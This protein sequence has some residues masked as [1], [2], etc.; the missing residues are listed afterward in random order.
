[1]TEPRGLRATSAALIC[2]ALV[3][4]FLTKPVHLD[5][6]NFLVLAKGAAM[7][8]WRPHAISINWQGTTER[9]F[10]VLSN[11][12]GIG[13]WLAPLWDAPVWAQRMWI[14]L[15]YTSDP[16]EDLTRLVCRC[17]AYT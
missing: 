15:L 1:M 13:W 7:D 9:A 4:P 2:F 10:D 8:P 16:S 12:P 11:P 3:L 17:C 14:C 6:A 5:D